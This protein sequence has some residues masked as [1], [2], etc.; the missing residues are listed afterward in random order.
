MSAHGPTPC[1]Y[2]TTDGR[3]CPNAARRRFT[4]K[5]T[6]APAS[7]SGEPIRYFAHACHAHTPTARTRVVVGIELEK[8]EQL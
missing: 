2:E 5:Q 7:I 6:N 3:A 8:E 1:E 4:W